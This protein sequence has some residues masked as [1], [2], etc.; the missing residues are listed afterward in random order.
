[1][2]TN[3]DIT[4]SLAGKTAL[5]TGASS[6]IGAFMAGELGKAGAR[7]ALVGRRQ[8]RL[9]AVLAGYDGTSIALNLVGAD[10]ISGLQTACHDAGIKPDIIV[11]AAGVNHRRSADDISPE[12]W[13]DTIHLNLSVP[14]LV[15]QAFVPHMKKAGWGRII[16]IASLQSTRAFE[17]GIAYGAAKGGIVQLTRAMAEAWSRHGI[18]ANAIAPGFFPTELTAPVFDNSDLANHHAR[19]TAMGRNGE[20][21]DLRGP[22]LFF[23]SDASGYVTGQTLPVDGGYT[24]K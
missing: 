6:G 13:Q 9:D 16:N 11:N 12:L 5:V 3:A 23:A 19:N 8:D 15:A 10:A 21:S 4:V 17:N 2:S 14:F 18:M 1:M 7:L 20:L 22:L 24:A